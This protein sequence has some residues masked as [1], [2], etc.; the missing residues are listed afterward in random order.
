MAAGIAEVSVVLSFLSLILFPIASV[1][2]GT[3]FF[4]EKE[5]AEFV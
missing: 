1:I 3:I 4:K 5:Q 2:L